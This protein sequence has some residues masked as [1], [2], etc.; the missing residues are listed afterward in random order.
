[1]ERPFSIPGQCVCGIYG[2]QFGIGRG[3]HP[4]TF[5][6]PDRIKPQII[7]THNSFIYPRHYT[8]RNLQLRYIKNTYISSRKNFR[9]HAFPSPMFWKWNMFVNLNSQL[10]L[11]IMTLTVDIWTPRLSTQN[12][13]FCCYR[14][15]IFFLCL[16]ISNSVPTEHYLV[17]FLIKMYCSI[18]EAEIGV[19][20]TIYI[21]FIFKLLRRSKKYRGVGIE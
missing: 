9:F 13:S 7:S 18:C 21:N 4:S 3:F 2:G 1:M 10:P 16:T 14:N 17:Q 20:E 15:F 11:R 12:S 8:L 5:L 6:S 19:L